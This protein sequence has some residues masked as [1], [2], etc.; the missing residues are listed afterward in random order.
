MISDIGSGI[1]YR[2]SRVSFYKDNKKLKVKENEVLLEKI[3]WVKIKENIPLN[4]KYTKPAVSHDGKYQYLSIGIEKENKQHELTNE[5]IGI[6]VGVKELTV[7][8]NGMV[9]NNINKTKKV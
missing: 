4:C 3:G 2:K 8:S 1:N 6:D 7:C 5:T 9:F